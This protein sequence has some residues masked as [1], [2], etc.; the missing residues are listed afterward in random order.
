M[1]MEEGKRILR[2]EHEVLLILQ[3]FGS[4]QR[5]LSLWLK[6]W[7]DMR[8]YSTA[9]RMA[10]S[11]IATLVAYEDGSQIDLVLRADISATRRTD[12]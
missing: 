10:S 1:G 3:M 9:I 6:K 12:P 5:H 11:R 7:A 8:W 4:T 2:C